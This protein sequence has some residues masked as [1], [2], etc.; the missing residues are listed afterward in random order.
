MPITVFM[1]QNKE[2][3]LM[4]GKL[5]ISVKLKVLTGLHIGGSSNFSVIGAVDSPVIKDPRTGLPIIPG[6]SLKGKLRT[7]LAKSKLGNNID[8]PENDPPEVLRLFG[9]GTSGRFSDKP[10]KGRLQFVDAFISNYDDLSNIGITEI[11]SENTINRV[12]LRANPRHIERVISGSMFDVKIVYDITDTNDLLLDMTNLSKALKLL[13]LDYL[14]GHGTRG[15]GRISFENFEV[16]ILSETNAVKNTDEIL[17]LFKEVEE[18]EL[19][20]I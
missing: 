16:N 6:S 1:L 18:Y 15:S 3:L 10:L 12:T 13:Q 14:G 20:S 8:K 7:M 17:K 5:I 2:G 9:S 19:L 4:Y 11:K